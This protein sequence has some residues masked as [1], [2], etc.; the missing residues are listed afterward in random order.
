MKHQS[1]PVQVA[2]LTDL[3]KPVGEW[4]KRGKGPRTIKDVAYEYH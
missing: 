3:F 4:V 2:N 1:Y